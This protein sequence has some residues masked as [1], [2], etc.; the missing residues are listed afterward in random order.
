MMKEKNLD[1]LFREKLQNYEQEPP[2]YLLENILNGLAQNRR[3]KRMIWWK[4]AGVA[5]ALLLAFVAGWQFNTSEKDQTAGKAFVKHSIEQKANEQTV[6]ASAAKSNGTTILAQDNNLSQEKEQK[7]DSGLKARSKNNATSIMAET[8]LKELATEPVNEEISSLKPRAGLLASKEDNISL[9]EKKKNA[10]MHNSVEKSIDQQIMELNQQMITAEKINKQK[11]RWLVG[12]QVS[13]EYNGAQSSHS[14][15]YASNMLKTQATKLDLAGGVSVEYKKGKRWSV[16]SGVYYSGIG[17]TS[18]NSSRNLSYANDGANYLNNTIVKV[19]A[20]KNSYTINSNAG[21][22]EL[23][24]I[25]AGMVLGASLDD[26]N[27]LASAVVVSQNT[28]IQDFDY[29]EIPLYLRYNLIESRFGISMLGG[30]SSNILVGNKLYVD[31]DLGRS[32]VGKT[33][34]LETFNYSG[35]F[36]LAFKYGL[37]NKLSLSVEPR[38]KYF[39]NSLSSNSDVTYKP[40]TF[41]VFTGLT[42]E[43]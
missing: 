11:A 32:L 10:R 22:V 15:A 8:K 13:P 21:E 6:V 17:Q 9:R 26:K 40:Y 33:K 37:T 3:K 35:T 5:A 23:N 31:G 25:P 28:F 14:Q 42:Y 19:D 12:A 30:V 29:L 38:F 43:F 7:S 41:G 39:I 1:D 18:G 36:G 24:S 16:Q 4:V 27:Y 2:A 20:S 34:D